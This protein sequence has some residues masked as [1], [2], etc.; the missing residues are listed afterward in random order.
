MK[1]PLIAVLLLLLVIP[2]LSARETFVIDS[3]HVDV[4][5]SD[6]SKSTFNEFLDLNFTSP[7]HGIIRDIQYRFKPYPFKSLSAD[8]SNIM[9]NVDAVLSYNGD[10]ISLRLGNPD[11]YVYGPVYYHIMYDYLLEDDGNRDYDEFY[12]NLLSPAW[13][14]TIGTFSFSVTFPHEVDPDRIWMTYG[15]YGSTE[16]FDYFL[17]SDRKTVSGV[18]YNLGPYSAVTLR[19]EFCDGYF[20]SREV[21]KDYGD[22]FKIIYS[23]IAIFALFFI[24]YSYY[25]LGRDKEIIAPVRFSPPEG[26]SSLD[27]GYIIDNTVTFDK[28]ILSMFFYFA[29]KGYMKIEE[30]DKDDFLFIK[31]KDIPDGRPS[32]EKRLFSLLFQNS[33]S[34]DVKDLAKR[35]F[36]I[37]SEEKISP[38]IERYYEKN[39]P[40]FERKSIQRASIIRAIGIASVIL[41]ATFISISSMGELTLFLLFPSLIA[42]ALLSLTGHRYFSN[43]S[44]SGSIRVLQIIL[45]AIIT[46]ALAFVSFSLIHISSGRLGISIL[47]SLINASLVFSSSFFSFAVNKRSDFAD[48]MLS[49]IL[50]YKEFLEKVEMEQLRALIEEDPEFYYHNLSYAIALN[51]EESYSRKF[52]SLKVAYPSWYSSASAVGSY[53]M[54]HTFST[55]W[56]RA[57]SFE[58]SLITPPPSGGFKGGSGSHRGFSGFS[59][60]GFSGGGGRSW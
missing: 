16:K 6:D 34:V 30:R 52:E 35:N 59:G 18:A 12:V 9:T 32:Y 7:S 3:Y 22:L 24:Y 37:V 49:Q 48:D 46:G 11:E 44:L 60:G 25:T 43:N 13:D 20:S 31:L 54:W 28:D 8:V 2:I 57:Y 50:G 17:S 19:A 14:T 1:K 53:M 38:D 27:V 5:V 10:Y 15:E 4:S 55:R 36:S 29:D 51:L 41:F 58:R 26:L 42:F 56:R 33:D 40:L 47:L 39:H 23:A 21:K 45:I